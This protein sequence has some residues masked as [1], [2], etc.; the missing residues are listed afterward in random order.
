M[1]RFAKAHSRINRK[2]SIK[3]EKAGNQKKKKTKTN[4]ET[5]TRDLHKYLVL[6]NEGKKQEFAK[7]IDETTGKR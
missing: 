5:L 1:H 6:Q 4:K 3:D 7:K 2:T